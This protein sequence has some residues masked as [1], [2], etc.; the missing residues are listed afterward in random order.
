M[1]KP[2]EVSNRGL[3]IDVFSFGNDNPYRILL[4]NE[5]VEEISIFD[6]TS[7]ISINEVS[8]ISIIAN[9][10]ASNKKTNILNYIAKDT[11]VWI[12]DYEN[13]ISF[14]NEKNN[15]DIVNFLKGK[16]ILLMISHLTK[17]MTIKLFTI[18]IYRVHLIKISNYLLSILKILKMLAT[19]IIF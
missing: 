4:D 9:I 3:I 7:Q 13:L 18:P 8:E 2:G 10:E 17:N 14:D 6:V 5:I 15:L 12:N 11:L 1:C 16:Q 19:I